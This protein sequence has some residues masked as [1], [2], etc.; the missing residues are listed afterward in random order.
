MP[1][2]ADKTNPKF[3]QI[4]P[5]N[6]PTPKFSQITPNFFFPHNAPKFSH[7]KIFPDNPKI[8]PNN[9]PKLS[10]AP[11]FFKIPQNFPYT[12]FSQITPKNFPT[13]KVFPDNIHP[14]ISLIQIPLLRK[15]SYPSTRKKDITT[16]DKAT[17][18]TL[19]GRKLK[20]GTQH[21]F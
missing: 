10:P 9:T 7:P 3:S 21:L 6:F 16:L 8:S 5:P 13:P 20:P 15:L 1:D 17:H 18:W 4:T 2:T 14:N 11:I 12:K 19:E